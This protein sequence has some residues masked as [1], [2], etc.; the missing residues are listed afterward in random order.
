MAAKGVVVQNYATLVDGR[1]EVQIDYVLG[2]GSRQR[3]GWVVTMD[4]DDVLGAS[5]VPPHLRPGAPIPSLAEA[6]ACVLA[7]LSLIHI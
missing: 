6:H 1:G 5:D 3:W 2:D 4:D 7:D